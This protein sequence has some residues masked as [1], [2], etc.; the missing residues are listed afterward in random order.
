MNRFAGSFLTVTPRLLFH[1]N[2]HVQDELVR[3][4]QDSMDDSLLNESS[5]AS[6]VGL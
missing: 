6:S 2:N 4:V 1:I 5:H 3:L